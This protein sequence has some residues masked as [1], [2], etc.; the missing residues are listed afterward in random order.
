MTITRTKVDGKECL[1]IH[2]KFA[3]NQP[4][5]E[6]YT[7]NNGIYYAKINNI[8]YA[9]GYGKENPAN[10]S[11]EINRKVTQNKGAEP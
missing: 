9:L 5:A 7:G 4:N 1:V 6:I 10:V 11:N 8:V 2:Y 3:I